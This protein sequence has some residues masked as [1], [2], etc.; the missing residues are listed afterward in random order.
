[1]S[2]PTGR[3]ERPSVRQAARRAALDAQAKL[4]AQRQERDKRL[5]ASATEV[6]VALGERDSA[7]VRYEQRAGAALRQLLDGEHLTP[8]EV[9]QWCGPSLTRQDIAR[10]RRLGGDQ[11]RPD[12]NL[13]R[14]QMGD[15]KPESSSGPDRPQP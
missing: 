11:Q 12:R 1:M 2:E 10:L 3:R 15:P 5:A 6:L 7:V 9:T 4:R 13:E 14:K 8:A